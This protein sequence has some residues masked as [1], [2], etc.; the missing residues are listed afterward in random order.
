MIKKA[1]FTVIAALIY[2]FAC[3]PA[4][5]SAAVQHI[6]AKGDNL[7][8]ISRKYKVSVDE[9]KS[10]NHLKTEKLKI[11]ETLR[12]PVKGSVS[13]RA[14][15]TTIKTARQA[16]F[17]SPVNLTAHTEV[18][19]VKKGDTLI[20]IARNYGMSVNE[21]KKL[22]GLKKNRLKTG[23][24]LNVPVAE[25]ETETVAGKGRQFLETA[26]I[27]NALNDE[28]PATLEGVKD[29][30]LTANEE[31]PEEGEELRP[32]DTSQEDILLKIASRYLGVPYR[33]GGSTN[34]GIDCSAFVQKVFGFLSVD[35]PRTAREQFRTG[36]KVAKGDLKEGD[37]VFFKTYARYASHV[38]IYIGDNKFIHASSRGKK[39]SISNLDAPYY[40]K[41][42][43]GAKRMEVEKNL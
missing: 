15:Q 19:K 31:A 12:L 27:S 21:L 6:V 13:S 18:Y 5:S 7:Y 24:E 17:K 42:F 14:R 8:S 26:S 35:L 3:H 4:L 25:P 40:T 1:G 16:R 23:S 22:N 33:F 43:I 20:T 30:A 38:G 37:L 34:N 29:E 36:Q 41:R 32:S 28:Q 11:G 2:L 9:L 39:V 10:A